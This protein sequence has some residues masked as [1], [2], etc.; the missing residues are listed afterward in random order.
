MAENRE[1]SSSTSNNRDSSGLKSSNSVSELNYR[2]DPYYLHPFDTSGLQL[3]QEH[4]RLRGWFLEATNGSDL[5]AYQN[6]SFVDSAVTRWLLNSMN[7][8]LYEAY[9][10]THTAHEIWKELEEKYGTNNRP[11]IFHVKKKLALLV[12]VEAI[13]MM[14]K[15]NDQQKSIVDTVNIAVINAVNTRYIDRKK[16]K[17]SRCCTHS[18][19]NGH[20]ADTCFKKHGYPDWFKEYK[21]QKGSSHQ[22]GSEMDK[23][24]MSEMIQ[25]ELKK[26]LKEKSGGDES[27]FV[28]FAGNVASKTYNYFGGND[29]GVKWIVDSG[30]SNHITGNLTL[31][32]D[33]R[34]PKGSNNTEQ[35]PDGVVKNVKLIGRAKIS[36]ALSLEHVLFV[37]DFKYNLIS[38]QLTKQQLV[39][40]KMVKNLYVLKTKRKK[41]KELK[42]AMCLL[43]GY[44]NT[45]IQSEEVDSVEEVDRDREVEEEQVEV[46][47]SH[48]SNTG[49]LV[50]AG[51][52]RH[53]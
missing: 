18:S 8:E 33:T 43:N 46:D 29:K 25:E 41:L 23:R 20:T 5:K 27:Y 51:N 4:A 30:A 24:T 42:L 34:E 21:N 15:G 38:D 16:E 1:L 53:R 52:E 47:A 3:V 22:K 12:R 49:V 35:L 13:A 9:M 10:F 28:D 14:T 45:Q 19:R 26:M 40:G 44:E 37:P 50:E 48:N 2:R 6:L 11:Q 7:T 39:H 36:D 31:L 32:S 17:A